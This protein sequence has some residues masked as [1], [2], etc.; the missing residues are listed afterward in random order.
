MFRSK[1]L[2]VQPQ[3]FKYKFWNYLP[4]GVCGKHFD[5]NECYILECGVCNKSFHRTCIKISKKKY[6]NLI[7]NGNIFICSNKCHSTILPLSQ[8][9]DIDF[10]SALFGENEFPCG[11]CKRDCLKQ[12]ACIQCSI[13]GTW[14]HFECSGLTTREFLHD[15][16]YFCSSKCAVCVLSIT[17]HFCG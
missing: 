1:L 5:S 17:L 8:C 3:S 4:Y 2:P 9:N 7:Q 13:C 11:K 15:V 16:Y 14:D 6:S 10:F 12:T